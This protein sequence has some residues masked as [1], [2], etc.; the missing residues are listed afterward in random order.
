MRSYIGPRREAVLE[1]WGELVADRASGPGFDFGG[2][3]RTVLTQER[4]GSFVADPTERAFEALWSEDVLGDSVM[5]G[6]SAV[7]ERHDGSL[8]A[9]AE[10][11]AEMRGAAAYDEAWESRFLVPGVVW[12][13]FGRLH[14]E[15][16]PIVNST[17]VTGLSRMGFERPTSYEAVR[18][19]WGAFGDVY[20]SVVGHGTAGT[21][22]EVSLHHE[23]SEFLW[24]VV[25]TDSDEVEAMLNDASSEYRPVVG[26]AD[27]APLEADLV[28]SGH[29][30]HLDGFV[31]AYANGGFEEDGPGDLWNQGYW[32]D[33]KDAYLRHMDDV[34]RPRYDLTD[35]EPEAVPGLVEDLTER[36]TLSATIPTYLLGGRTGGILWSGFREHSTENPGEAAATL[37]YLFDESVDVTLRLDRFESFYGHLDEGGGALMSLATMLLTFA[38]PNEYVFY[39]YGLMSDFFGTYGNFEVPTG[40]NPSVYWKLNRACQDQLLEPLQERLEGKDATLLDVYTLLYV[41]DGNYND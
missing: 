3:N 38:Y 1:A 25:R 9:V 40:F 16:A 8:S 24:F 33:W 23:M 14:P 20:E 18:S 17:C 19:V 10:T 15:S 39:K 30:R 31:D 6:V 22:H 41:W 35:L 7:L 21:E 29:E 2:E 32:E 5:G 36:T 37:S 12:E 13:L 4:V 11:L 34:V 26:W 28:L 27:E